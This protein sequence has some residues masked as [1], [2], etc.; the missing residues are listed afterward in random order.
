M[1]M[2]W[3]PTL[4]SA[5]LYCFPWQFGACVLYQVGMK[6]DASYVWLFPQQWRILLICNMPARGLDSQYHTW[7]GII[8][9][10]PVA[11]SLLLY[12]LPV[13]ITLLPP[14]VTPS[15]QLALCRRLSFLLQG[16]LRPDLREVEEGVDSRE[17]WQHSGGHWQHFSGCFL[18]P[19]VGW[20]G[21][22][23]KRER[24][25]GREADAERQGRS[26]VVQELSWWFLHPR[27]LYH[28]HFSGNKCPH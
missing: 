25:E 3:I 10:S 15:S 19:A 22:H 18:M 24:G 17:A 1:N 23:L 5:S 16:S 13:S 9:C 11:V 6:S 12:L 7:V 27:T 21:K 2:V 4:G 8:A 26:E 20:T 14:V 28:T